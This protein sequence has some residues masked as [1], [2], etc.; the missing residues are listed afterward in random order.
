MA[1]RIKKS[2]HNGAKNG[3]G[4]WETRENAK[5]MSNKVRREND[6]FEAASLSE[7]ERYWLWRKGYIDEY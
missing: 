1:N 6:K 7:R 3:G 5:A 4:A 2:E